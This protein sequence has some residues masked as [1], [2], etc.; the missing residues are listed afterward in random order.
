MIVANDATVKAGAFFPQT[1]RRS[2]ARSASRSRQPAAV[3]LVDSA[4]VFLPLQ[5]E[6]FPDE[7]R[8]RPDL[9]Q[10]RVLS[11]RACRSSPPSWAT[12][13]P[14]ARYLPV[15]CDKVLMTEGSGLCTSRGRRW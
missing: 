7:G 6:V 14:A 1:A 3:Y 12:A 13:S 8:L 11:P 15:L 10:Q 9:P 5:D 2:S 4:G